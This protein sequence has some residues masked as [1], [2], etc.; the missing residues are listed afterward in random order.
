[1]QRV[2]HCS[3]RHGDISY[4][5]KKWCAMLPFN[6]VHYQAVLCGHAHC[7]TPQH[8]VSSE[9]GWRLKKSGLTLVLMS[10]SPVLKWYSVG[11][12]ARI[13][14]HLSQTIIKMHILMCMQTTDIIG[15]QT[16]MWCDV[17]RSWTLCESFSRL[18]KLRNLMTASTS[19]MITS[20]LFLN[21]TTKI[22]NK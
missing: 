18:F 6:G 15:D 8:P 11:L 3:S 7:P 10:A 13:G 20:E 1:M 5:P 4:G 22:I 2:I 14:V 16:S 19:W 12:N 9:I 17:S 21:I